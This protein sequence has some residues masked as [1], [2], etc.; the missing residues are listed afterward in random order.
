MAPGFGL[1]GFGI[2]P[3]GPQWNVF[4]KQYKWK[5]S[6][7][8][9]RGRRTAEVWHLWGHSAGHINTS[10]SIPVAEGRTTPWS[11]ELSM[12]GFSLAK[13]LPLTFLLRNGVGMRWA[14]EGR[15]SSRKEILRSRVSGPTWFKASLRYLKL[16]L[17][18][19][20]TSALNHFFPLSTPSLGKLCKF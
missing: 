11:G 2:S 15:W 4:I 17:H 16:K 20:S 6:S 3:L 12:W 14:E 13:S 10:H 1:H 19:T 5:D 7:S 18:K 9:D 8:L